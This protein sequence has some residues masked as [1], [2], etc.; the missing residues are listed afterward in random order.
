MGIVYGPKSISFKQYL[1]NNF[2]NSKIMRERCDQWRFISIITSYQSYDF[3][4]DS[5]EDSY[6]LIISINEALIK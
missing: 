1:K 2:R 3:I 5:I 4:M 6:D